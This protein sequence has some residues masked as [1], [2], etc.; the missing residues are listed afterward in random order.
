MFCLRA[1]LFDRSN[2][3]RWFCA[4]LGCERWQQR[5]DLNVFPDHVVSKD[6]VAG[7][8][9]VAVCGSRY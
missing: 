6:T 9:L 3:Q 2:G 7:R 4:N 5:I 1:R 8:L